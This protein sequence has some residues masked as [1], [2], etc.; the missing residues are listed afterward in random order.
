MTSLRTHLCISAA[1]IALTSTTALAEEVNKKQFVD[2][3]GLHDGGAIVALTQDNTPPDTTGSIVVPEE[4]VSAQQPA[5]AASAKPRIEPPSKQPAEVEN[6][7]EEPKA[8]PIAARKPFSS[9]VFRSFLKSSKKFEESKREQLEDFYSDHRYKPQ[10]TEAS[11]LSAAGK[12]LLSAVRN[13]SS[14]GLRAE[15]YLPHSYVAPTNSFAGWPAQEQ[16]ELDLTLAYLQFAGDLAA[17]AVKPS[18]T[19][20]D[21]YLQPTRPSNED[22]FERLEK[23]S[24]ISALLHALQPQDPSY[25]LLQKELKRYRDLAKTKKL[26]RV[27]SGPTLRA[28][29]ADS[30][31]ETI[32]QRLAQEGYYTGSL[33]TQDRQYDGDVVE[34][35]KAFQ[36]A[37]GLAADGVVGRNTLAVMNT[38]ID[39]RVR[40]IEANL[41]RLRWYDYQASGRF[42]DVNI[43]SQ[44]LR[45]VENGRTVHS[46]RVVVGKPKYK[47][48]IFSHRIS[49]A[50]VNP[51]W[52]IPRS[53]ALKTYLPR[54]QKDPV[55]VMRQG[56]RVFH[57]NREIDPRSII[58]STVQP[59]FFNFTLQ[60]R[61]G[62]NNAL[63][64]VKYMFPNRHAIYLHDTPSKHLFSRSS[65][66]LSH[67]CI[68]VEDPFAFGEKL[69]S[70]D[71][72]TQD[73][74]AQLRQRT[75]D[76]QRINLSQKVPV[77]LRYFTAF[78][79][80]DGKVQF[81]HDIYGH[82][83]G[84]IKALSAQNYPYS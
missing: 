34:A 2:P 11:G 14:H 70:K 67:G 47:T 16:V 39:D 79:G 5:P 72:W 38:S 82:D 23:A 20:D 17:G 57:G 59:R 43:A 4:E 21:I 45:I 1:L 30:R 69:F 84:L 26:V 35:V 3:L 12:E 42:V 8:E 31:V 10:W 77:H 51:T 19:G 54:L 29:D 37:N 52:T 64:G 80:E 74:F 61:P 66:A 36:R 62:A 76:P 18:R 50:E 78:I 46:T 56:I 6:Q 25:A 65:R 28:G 60:Q 55:A 33:A 44:M 81:R 75:Q 48:P 15:D 53:I 7:R 71:G 58:W 73:R 32:K 22:L 27:P 49:Y 13:A 40:Q 24:S 63:G 68:R 41:E 83:K 9:S